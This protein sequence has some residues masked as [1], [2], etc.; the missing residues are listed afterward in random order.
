MI[1]QILIDLLKSK[2]IFKEGFSN[3]K[4]ISASDSFEEHI[5]DRLKQMGFIDYS[6]EWEDF[7]K[8]KIS[9]IF[10]D[11][12]TKRE[13]QSFIRV[14]KQSLEDSTFEAIKMLKPDRGFIE[15]P[16]SSKRQ[17]DI[18][19]WWMGKDGQRK[20][21]L[22]DIKTGGG[23]HPKVN[24]RPIHPDHLIV[25][26]SRNDKV[27]DNPTTMTFSRDVFDDEDHYQAE[28]ARLEFEEW[29]K[30]MVRDNKC[31]I[32]FNPRARVEIC[33]LAN[34]WFDAGRMAREAKAIDFIR[35]KL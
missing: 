5:S 28:R 32:R 25:F 9:K 15:Q 3:N 21:L 33:S 7:K 10:C 30:Q 27:R 14:F 8:K 23:L 12:Q 1:D 19:I 22:V 2:Q 18:L 31:T 24:D 6:Q 29:K 20:Y 13:A 26:N 17:P 35:R 4:R 16:L 11:Y 34:N